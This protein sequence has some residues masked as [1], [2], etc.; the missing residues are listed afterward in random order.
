MTLGWWSPSLPRRVTMAWCVLGAA[1]LST[2]KLSPPALAPGAVTDLRVSMVSDTAV[3]LTW[4]E[5]SSSITVP[6]K[7]VL[8]YGFAGAFQ[9]G[10]TPDVLTGGCSAPVYGSTAGGGRTRSCVLGG[11]LPNR[12]YE[13]QLVAYTGTLK[14]NAI[15]GPLSN[16][17][18]ATTASRY[19]PLVVWRP[20]MF[21]DSVFLTA[22]SVDDFGEIRFPLRGRFRM[23]DRRV[24]FYDS[25]G[26]V[27]AVGYVVV[28][29]P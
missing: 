1:A 27:V 5:V 14:V 3:T 16:L 10:G 8:R 13:F 9:W 20:R 15:F 18:T 21:L 24:T 12:A 26:A 19:G 11:L 7:Y 6:A 23:G 28:T 29:A 25:S 17:A 22:A 4:T 2:P